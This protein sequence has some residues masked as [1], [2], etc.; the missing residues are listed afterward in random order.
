VSEQKSRIILAII[1]AI[2]SVTLL[3]T[4]SNSFFPYPEPTP[5][6]PQFHILAIDG[7]F[8]VAQGESININLN[9]VSNSNETHGEVTFPLFLGSQYENQPFQGYTVIATPPSPYSSKLPWAQID[10]STESKPFTATFTPNP[11]ILGT[12]ETKSVNLTIYAAE[13]ATLGAY[14]MDVAMCNYPMTSYFATGFQ[15]TVQLKSN[16]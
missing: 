5:F 4:V 13:N 12:N 7:N 16:P 2:V 8:S 14:N 6:T 3:A 11:A 9:V 1:L 10:T 15:L